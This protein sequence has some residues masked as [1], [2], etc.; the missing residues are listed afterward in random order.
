[1]IYSII[2]SRFWNIF[3]DIF[4]VTWVYINQRLRYL[5][6]RTVVQWITHQTAKPKDWGSNPTAGIKWVSTTLIHKLPWVSIQVAIQHEKLTDER[7]N[8]SIKKYFGFLFSA[9]FALILQW[10]NFHA[11]IMHV[12]CN[13]NTFLNILQQYIT[14]IYS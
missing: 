1:M 4:H 14:A 11:G 8:S 3:N 13:I 12:G 2:Y 6:K 5:H 7:F 10:Q 9:K